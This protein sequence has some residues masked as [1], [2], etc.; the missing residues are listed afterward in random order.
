MTTDIK[1]DVERQL[2]E[3]LTVIDWLKFSEAK[4]TGSW[5]CPPPGSA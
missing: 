1:R 5:D 3:L 2:S 4:N